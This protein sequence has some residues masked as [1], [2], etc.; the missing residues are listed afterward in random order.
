MTG[1]RSEGGRAGIVCAGNWIVDLVH[2]LRDWP[3]KSAIAHILS[4]STGVGGGP[5]NVALGL[6]RMGAPY[7]I[8]P[9][10]LIGADG[11]GDAILRQCREAGLSVER[12]RRTDRA[13][14][15][16]SHVMTVPGDSRTFFYHPGANDIL[17]P[18][19]IDMA[20]LA[21]LD[22]RIFY[23]GY[24]NLL[25]ALDRIGP[26]GRTGAAALLA[27]A[28]AAGMTTCVDLASSTAPDYAAVVAATSPEIDVLF[29]N[30]VEAARATGRAIAGPRD[31][32][33][34]AEAARALVRGGVRRAVILHSAERTI[35]CEAGRVDIFAPD[36]VPPG[37]VV[38]PV[39]AG[40]AFAAGILHGL[41]EGWDRA[42]AVDLA[43]RAAAAC[44][45]GRSSTDGLGALAGALARD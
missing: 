37:A 9:V 5:A 14:T 22:A 35:W 23:L 41:H 43:F 17:R 19:D 8:H 30:E 38:S 40:D 45:R 12:L 44:L 24:L 34:M 28:R 4:Q 16:Q 6:H 36:P 1:T 3:E 11:M 29:G 39:G 25:A 31:V 27:A 7:P 2:E 20:E 18:A 13:A 15:S 21:A 10:G 42:R 32:D 33:G 26:D